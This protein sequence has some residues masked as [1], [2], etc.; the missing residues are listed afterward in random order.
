MPHD[1]ESAYRSAIL[2]TDATKLIAKI[3][4]ARTA[5]CASLLELDASG[6][7]GAER[8]RLID[9]LRTLEL[10]RRVEVKLPA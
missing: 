9:A 6:E 7:H 3:D 10:I 8:Q 4:L 1:W 2:E 5:V